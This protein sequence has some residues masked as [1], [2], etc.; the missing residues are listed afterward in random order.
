MLFEVP[1]YNFFA[2]NSLK[3]IL[4]VLWDE[5]SENNDNN[6]MHKI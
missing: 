6:L 1:D 4:L 5:K 3:I 2:K